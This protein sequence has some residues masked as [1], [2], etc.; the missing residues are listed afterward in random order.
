MIEQELRQALIGLIE[1]VTVGPFPDLIG[2]P[3]SKLTQSAQSQQSLP[4]S[5]LRIK[6]FLEKCQH[7][8]G[9]NH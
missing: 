4:V 3:G 5:F 2:E 9:E 6:P 1:F 8:S 7:F